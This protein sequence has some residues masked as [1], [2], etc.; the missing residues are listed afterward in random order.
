LMGNHYHLVIETP[1]RT[2]SKGMRQLNGVYTQFFNRRHELV[3]HLYQGRF[4]SILVERDSYLIELVRYI[5]L[6][7]VRAGIVKSVFDWRWSSFMAL[8]GDVSKP[9]WLCND[10]ILKQFSGNPRRA[11]MLFADFI[12]EGIEANKIWDEIKEGCILGS[13][14][15]VSKACSKYGLNAGLKKTQRRERK[16]MRKREKAIDFSSKAERNMAI[17]ERYTTG[18]YT[19]EELAGQFGIGK[20]TVCRIINAARD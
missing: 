19:M 1:E 11:R 6:N 15:F 18:C 9:S 10:W 5:L 2:L 16:A 13:H 17:V 3:G 8:I 7:P 12:G 14:S 4:K 20:A